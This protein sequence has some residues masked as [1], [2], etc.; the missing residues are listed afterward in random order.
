MHV[1]ATV[2]LGE[3]APED[4]SVELYY[5][6]IG[7]KGNYENPSRAEM[8]PKDNGKDG[9]FAYSIDVTC[10]EAGKQG[11]SVRVLPKHGRLVHQFV[12]GAIRWA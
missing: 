4:V 3:L 8:S 10:S 2:K 12:P 9:T 11:I 6:S 7:S 5:G 1:E